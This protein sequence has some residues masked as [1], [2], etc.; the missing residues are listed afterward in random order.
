[1][2]TWTSEG[3]RKPYMSKQS[4]GPLLW[5]A[6]PC[7]PITVQRHTIYLVVQAE[8]LGGIHRSFLTPTPSPPARPAHKSKPPPPAQDHRRR[9]SA[10]L[11]LLLRTVLRRPLRVP[12]PQASPHGPASC[13]AHQAAP[14]PGPLHWLRPS[15]QRNLCVRRPS[16]PR[17]SGPALMSLPR[18]VCLPRRGPITITLF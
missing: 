3:H 5:S 9:L 17:Y 1:M 15:S 16:A 10:L 7:V 12:G 2:A 13:L 6:L 11:T 14:A 4:S 8:S 18:T